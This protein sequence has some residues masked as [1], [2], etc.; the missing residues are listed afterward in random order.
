MEDIFFK[1]LGKGKPVILI[2]GFCE[3]LEIWNGLAEKLAKKYEVFVIDLPGFGNSRLPP[4]PFS[5][6][7]ISEK[8]LKWIDQLKINLPVVIGHS[9]GGY[10]AL[11]MASHD[12]NKIAGL[13]LFHSTP[14]SD[15]EERKANRSRVIEFVKK[16]GVGPFVDTY[17]PGLFFDMRHHAIPLVDRIARKTTKE[18]LLAYTSAMR[19]RPSSIDFLTDFEKP[20]L[21][22]AGEKDS[23]IPMESVRHYGAL[24]KKSTVC[25][26]KETAHMGMF[27]KPQEAE[28]AIT[29]FILSI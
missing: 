26:L 29:E 16:N 21:V 18:T 3:T 12:Q 8:I 13:G 24:P 11:A 14:H 5:I 2:H 23:I 4:A 6:I 27:E 28:A 15:S 1:K 20:V 9:L 22:L 19:E 25:I 17:V 7:D 10:V